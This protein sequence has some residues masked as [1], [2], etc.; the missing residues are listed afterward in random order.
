MT[1]RE[2][3]EFEK[4]YRQLLPNADFSHPN[5]DIEKAIWHAA[6][7]ACAAHYERQNAAETYAALKVSDE[8]TDPLER[9]RAFC[10]FAMKGKDW[11]DVESFFDAVT[12]HYESVMRRAEA[13]LAEGERERDALKQQAKIWAQE[14]RTQTATVHEIYRLCTGGKGEPGDWHG[15]EPVRELVAY[16]ERLEAAIRDAPHNGWCS[17]NEGERT[18]ECDCWKR[19]ALGDK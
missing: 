17:L 5:W 19:A 13:Q 7:Q 6:W 9:L 16:I 8:I 14:A 4:H 3:F 10:S 2:A 11:L 18:G 12:E 1:D 15:G